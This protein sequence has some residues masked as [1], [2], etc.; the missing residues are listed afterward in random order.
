MQ[1]R[2]RCE[3]VHR[4]GYRNGRNI[5]DGATK[6]QHE[7]QQPRRNSRKSR[8]SQATEWYTCPTK[9][10]PELKT[11]FSAGQTTAGGSVGGLHRLPLLFGYHTFFWR[12]LVLVFVLLPVPLHLRPGCLR[13]R[14]FR[15]M[16]LEQ[17]LWQPVPTCRKTR[18]WK[19]RMG[20]VVGCLRPR[21]CLSLTPKR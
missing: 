12:C 9:K 13:S 16:G 10:R 8:N 21:C 2:S 18:G 17:L 14:L 1:K 20:C 15:V 11:P 19:E 5:V 6:E 3:N 7:R 4:E